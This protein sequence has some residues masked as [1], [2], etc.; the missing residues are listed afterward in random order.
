M[1]ATCVPVTVLL[2]FGDQAELLTPTRTS[3]N[4]LRVPAAD[5]TADTGI[6]LEKLAGKRLTAV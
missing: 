5:I 6:P 3:D 4:P 2:T 1:N